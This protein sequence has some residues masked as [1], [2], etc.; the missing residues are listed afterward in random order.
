[1][2]YGTEGLT[3]AICVSL[4]VEAGSALPGDGRVLV[5]MGVSAGAGSIA[6]EI[7]AGLGF[8]V[9]AATTT[10]A[11]GDSPFRDI[12]MELGA[13]EVVVSHCY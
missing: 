3:A 6:V 8:S 5:S 4:L 11:S 7:L 13:R 10:M 1:M 12:L 9:I 2:V